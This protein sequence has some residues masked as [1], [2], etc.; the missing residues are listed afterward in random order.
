MQD[1][2]RTWLT[3]FATGGFLVESAGLPD[4]RGVAQGV[5]VELMPGDTSSISTSMSV[6][7]GWLHQLKQHA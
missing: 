4:V 2:D 7:W 5:F 6:G 1:S 3:T